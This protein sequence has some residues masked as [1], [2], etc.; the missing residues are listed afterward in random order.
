MGDPAHRR[1]MMTW[2]IWRPPRAETRLPK[3]GLSFEG[4]WDASGCVS[5]SSRR[6]ST[7]TSPASCTMA[8]ATNWRTWPRYDTLTAVEVPGCY[9]LPIVAKTLAASGE[10]RCHHLPRSRHPRR[11]AALRL[12]VVRNGER[13]PAGGDGHG[14]PGDLRRVT[15]DNEEQAMARVGGSAGHKG[16]EAALTAIEMVHTMNRLR[17]TIRHRPE[18]SPAPGHVGPRKGGGRNGSQGRRRRHPDQIED[19]FD[20]DAVA[21]GEPV[22]AERTGRSASPTARWRSSRN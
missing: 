22:D 18:G 16:R 1:A 7:P 10:V 17:G 8:A 3:D 14:R 11:Y 12:R 19:D 2:R 21:E 9:E 15:T 20:W 13:Y 5:P 4:G 6:G